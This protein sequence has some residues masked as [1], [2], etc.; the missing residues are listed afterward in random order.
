MRSESTEF[1][2]CPQCKRALHLLNSRGGPD[3]VSGVL[4][5]AHCRQ[6][7]PIITG[8]PCLL[9]DPHPF[10]IGFLP[11]EDIL[12]EPPATL[13]EKRG[14]NNL[15]LVLYKYGKAEFIRAVRQTARLSPEARARRFQ[16]SRT[17][18]LN[19]T[20]KRLAYRHSRLS[21]IRNVMEPVMEQ[22][23]W[24]DKRCVAM[25]TTL[26]N[27]QPER[28]LDIATGPGSLLCR[29][30]PRLTA[31]KAVGLEIFFE[32]CRLVM[33]E[34]A[35]FGFGKRLQMV[36]GDARLMPFADATFDC[37]SGWTALY[38]ISRYEAAIREAARVLRKGGHFVG[39]VHTKYPSHCRDL[40]SRSE[41]EEMIRCAHLPLNIH[42]VCGVLRASGFVISSKEAVGNCHLVVA[43]KK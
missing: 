14:R 3:I 34:A 7:Y 28:L 21:F 31:T 25:V 33:A 40:L 17:T 24:P 1:L 13:K 37:V 20:I 6:D 2:V 16:V 26:Q 29:A 36:H 15:G 32:A 22:R 23:F 42:E 8:V 35:Y 27:L 9:P 19:P 30:L 5:C 10:P 11:P 39:T 18:V 43:K 12:Q 4:Q 38:H 41:E